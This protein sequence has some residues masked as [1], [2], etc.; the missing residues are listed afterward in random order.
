MLT[1]EK[2]AVYCVWVYFLFCAYFVSSWCTINPFGYFCHSGNVATEYT[3]EPFKKG[4][5]IGSHFLMGTWQWF[6]NQPKIWLCN[7]TSTFL[8]YSGA[9]IST[10]PYQL[11][12][13]HFALVAYNAITSVLLPYK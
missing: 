11:D 2:A 4:K 5:E 7:K 1:Y 8:I 3:E 10:A 9:L 13:S 12:N 6:I